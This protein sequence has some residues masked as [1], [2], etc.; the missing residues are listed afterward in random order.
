MKV[1]NDITV[2][3]SD[4]M[5][6][7]SQLV[8]AVGNALGV[9]HQNMVVPQFIA[10]ALH[11]FV[12]WLDHSLQVLGRATLLVAIN[13]QLALELLYINHVLCVVVRVVRLGVVVGVY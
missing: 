5:R 10:E 1:I 8:V 7:R 11:V 2:V 9:R 13:L 6:Q 12:K 3:I 4:N